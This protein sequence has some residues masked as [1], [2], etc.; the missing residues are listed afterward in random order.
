MTRMKNEAKFNT[1]KNNG[2]KI[3]MGFEDFLFNFSK[4]NNFKNFLF[5][6][7]LLLLLLLF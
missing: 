4:K 7:L 6:L 2:Q 3:N 1:F 5:H